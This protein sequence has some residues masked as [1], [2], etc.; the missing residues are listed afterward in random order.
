MSNDENNNETEVEST[1]EQAKT[2]QETS[3]VTEEAVATE[4][5]PVIEESSD[6]AE[7]A[8]SKAMAIKESNPKLFFG[9]IGAVVIVILGVMMIGGGSKNPIPSAKVVNLSIGQTYSLK[10]VNSYD[11][12]ATV[13]L[14]EVPGSIAAYGEP[15]EGDE[16]KPCQQIAEGTKVKLLQIQ[17]AFGKAKFVQVEILGGKCANKQGW[18][19]SNNLN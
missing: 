14:V 13:R 9:A 17:E 1:E 5:S 3:N 4:E 7:S 6:D 15:K 11:P 12:S 10:A 18:A 16:K 2:E 8:V 19:V